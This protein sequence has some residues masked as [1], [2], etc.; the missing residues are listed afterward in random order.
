MALP[1]L[2]ASCSYGRSGARHVHPSCGGPIGLERLLEI[3][4]DLADWLGLRAHTLLSFSLSRSPKSKIVMGGKKWFVF[5]TCA[6]S[7]SR[8]N[9]TLINPS[10]K[11]KSPL[12]E[13][14]RGRGEGSPL[15]NPPAERL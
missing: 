5:T 2:Q 9:I 7:L 11:M 13:E 8:K 4:N 10:R 14:R 12:G 15:K 3:R 1:E 6:Q